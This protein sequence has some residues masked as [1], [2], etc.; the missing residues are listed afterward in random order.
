MTVLSQRDPDASRMSRHAGAGIRRGIAC[1]AAS[2]PGRAPM[3]GVTLIELMIAVVIIGIL[4][5]IAYPAY[6][7]QVRKSRR[8]DGKAAL[9]ALATR[10]EQ[11]YLDNKQYTSTLSSLGYTA[12]GSTYYSTESYYALTVTTGTVSCPAATCYQLN[13]TAQAKGGQNNET[14]CYTLTFDSTGAKGSKNSGGTT[15]SGCW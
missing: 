11:Y 9:Q 7:D 1:R 6:Q 15:T 5:A 3:R 10:L 2:V 13:A 4:A 8:S 12:V 14:T